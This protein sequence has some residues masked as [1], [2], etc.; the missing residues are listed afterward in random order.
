MLLQKSMHF[1]PRP[2]IRR[3]LE[4]ARAFPHSARQKLPSVA[5]LPHVRSVR[6]SFQSE[7]RDRKT[8]DTTKV[9]C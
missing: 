8:R 7:L 2:E 6:I 1:H 4:L 3:G 5:F 9:A